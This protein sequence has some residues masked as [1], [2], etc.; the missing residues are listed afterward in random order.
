MAP[1]GRALEAAEFI[2]LLGD[3]QRKTPPGA[4]R[5]VALAGAPASGKSTLA[6][7]AEAKL[8]EEMPGACAVLPMD[9]FH[10][11]DAVL[12]AR[13]WRARKGAPHT[14]DV[15]G[16]A[17]M[18]ARLRANREPAV[19][20]PRF[21]RGLEIARA[22]AVLIEPSV[23]LILVEG[24][25]LL[26]KEAPWDALAPLFDLTALIESD[27]ETRVARL[28]QRWLDHNLSAPEIAAKLE[29]NDLPNGRL[30]YANS[31]EADLVIVT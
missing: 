31:R 13:G 19:A 14:F 20:V 2:A 12:E 9:G 29:E 30:V 22:A 6:E 3:L 5:I 11:D 23:R 28:R 17:A 15:G 8:N 7:V 18:L 16:L 25:Y 4:R 26:L 10:Y 1:G 21:D 27:E 24:N